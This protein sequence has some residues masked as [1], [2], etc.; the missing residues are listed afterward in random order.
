MLLGDLDRMV[1]SY[2]KAL[3]NRGGVIN[4]TIANVTIE[5]NPDVFGNIDVDLSRWAASLFRRMGFVKRRKSLSKV[6][7]SD[8]SR[9]EI[10]YTGHSYDKHRSN[11]TEICTN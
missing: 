7:I 8:G 2:L 10:L 5:Q 1:Q 9:K 3:S 6:H 11:H 4:T